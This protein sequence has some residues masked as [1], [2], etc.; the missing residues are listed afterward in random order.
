MECVFNSVSKHG[1]FVK[2]DVVYSENSSLGKS[3]YILG[4][5]ID[6]KSDLNRAFDNK[7]NGIDLFNGSKDQLVWRCIPWF[8]KRNNLNHEVSVGLILP[9]VVDAAYNLIVDLAVRL[10]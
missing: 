6:L 2:G 4:F 5:P 10:T 8:K 9:G 1:L 7:E 3:E